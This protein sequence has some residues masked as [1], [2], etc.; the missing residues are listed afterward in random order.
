MKNYLSL[1]LHSNN[2]FIHDRLV[3]HRLACWVKL[4]ADDIL[5]LFFFYFF[6]ENRHWHFMY[7][8]FI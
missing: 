7:F 2:V 3:R 4:A 1:A 8:F 5:K 6:P